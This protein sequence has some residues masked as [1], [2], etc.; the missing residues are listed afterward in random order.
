MLRHGRLPPLMGG[1]L[2]DIELLNVCIISVNS[3]QPVW[4]YCVL[5]VIL[6]LE[7]ANILLCVEYPVSDVIVYPV[8]SGANILLL[9]GVD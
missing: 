9:A 8:C 5:Y 1:P 3:I 2:Y 7:G 4:C 6:Y